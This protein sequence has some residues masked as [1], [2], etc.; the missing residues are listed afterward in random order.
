MPV[1]E[2]LKSDLKNYLIDIISSEQLSKHG[3]I[4]EAY[5]IKI[6]MHFLAGQDG[7]EA[8]DV[9]NSYVSNVVEQMDVVFY[10]NTSQKK[11]FKNNSFS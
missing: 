9:A 8:T 5:A 11:I 7:Y 6:V 10:W 1:K 4:N 2:W 3:L